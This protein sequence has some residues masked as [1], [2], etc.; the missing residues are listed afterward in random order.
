MTSTA[1]PVRRQR[2]ELPDAWL[3]PPR[4]LGPATPVPHR[5]PWEG[6]RSLPSARASRA[7]GSLGRLPLPLYLPGG[8]EA[9]CGGRFMLTVPGQGQCICAPHPTLLESIH[10]GRTPQGLR[11]GRSGRR[12]GSPPHAPCAHGRRRTA[13]GQE[14]P[15]IRVHRRR[16]G[17]GAEW[18]PAPGAARRG[19]GPFQMTP[20]RP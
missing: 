19:T 7:D 9:T 10:E 8:R 14:E 1:Q 12:P 18:W 15:P 16:R 20:T 11:V 5:G 4:G 13:P 2:E 17:S 6:H 3:R